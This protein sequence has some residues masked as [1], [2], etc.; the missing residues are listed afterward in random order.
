MSA[1]W[2]S[3]DG[4]FGLPVVNPATRLQQAALKPRSP[5]SSRATMAG[6]TCRCEPGLDRGRAVLFSASRAVPAAEFAPPITRTIDRS[7][8]SA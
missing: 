4:R 6:Q 7:A 1:I 3:Y 8:T 5:R 2:R